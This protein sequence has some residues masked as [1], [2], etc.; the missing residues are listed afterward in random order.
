MAVC[1]YR[2]EDILLL[3]YLRKNEYNVC[4][5]TGRK[6]CDL[7]LGKTRMGGKSK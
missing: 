2:I 6:A 3:E 1:E 5:F 4:I 7:A